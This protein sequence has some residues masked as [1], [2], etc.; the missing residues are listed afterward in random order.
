MTTTKTKHIAVEC[1]FTP[2]V[3]IIR[4]EEQDLKYIPTP[5][6]NLSFNQIVND[7]KTGIRSFCIVGPY[8]VGKSA[9]LW[10]FDK[11]LNS[12]KQYFG[13]FN[14]SKVKKFHDIKIVGSY[15]S[16]KDAFAKQIGIRKKDYSTNDILIHLSRLYNSH[17]KSKTGLLIIVDEFG[18]FLEYAA[19]NNPE[20]ELYFIQEI[21]EFVNDSRQEILFISSLH[22]D[23]NG[24]ARNLT[25]T[26]QNEWDKVKGR[27]K[28]ITFSEPVEQLLFLASERLAEMNIRPKNNDLD[29]L[30]KVIEKAK[31]FPLR[32]YFDKH[33]ATKLLP[34]DILAA[35]TLTLALQKYGQNE[36]SLFSFL[37]SSDFKGLKDY[38]QGYSPF[39]LSDVYDYLIHNYHSFLTTK[40]N[41]HYSQW[42][43]I[44]VAIERVEGVFDKY[45]EDEI[46]LVKT[47]GL[48]TIFSPA[49]AK[50]D[51]NF[52]TGYSIFALGVSQPESIIREL[53][54][55]KIILYKSYSS[56]YNLFE[57]TDLDIE[58]AIDEAG[59]V[60]EKVTNVIHHLDKYYDFPY[61]SAKAATYQKGTPRFFAFYLSEELETILPEG[62]VDGFINL[63][64]SNSVSEKEIREFSKKNKEAVLFGLFK[65][66]EEIK[67]ILFEIQKVEKVK[68][69]NVDD[70]VAMRELGNILQSQVKRLNYAVLK[71]IYSSDSSISWYFNGRKEK[72][73]NQRDFNQ[74]LSRIVNTVYVDTPI[75]KNE[76]VNKTRVSG[77]ISTARKSLFKNLTSSW[78]EED[79][80]FVSSK[81]PPEKTIYLSLVK[82]TG[83][84]RKGGNAYFLGSPNE[85]SFKPLWDICLQFLDSTRDGKRNLQEMVDLL[86]IKPFKLKKGFI[87]YWLPLFLLCKKDDFALF[88]NDTYVPYLTD[89]TLDLIS[90]NPKDFDVKAFDIKGVKLDIFNR[91]R[92]LLNQSHSQ[93]LTGN[94][95]I[96]TIRPFLVF[97]KELPQYSKNTNSLHKRTI[98]LRNAIAVSKDPEEAFFDH[99]PKALGFTINDLQK[100]PKAL[101]QFVTQFKDCIKELRSS[102]DALLTDFETFIK[103][104]IIGDRLKFPL[105]KQSL[106]KRFSN[107]KIHLLSP[108]QKTFVQRVNSELDESKTWLNS[109][110]QACIGKALDI[111][112]DED[113]ILLFDRFKE[114]THELDNLCEISNTG[115][116]EDR[117]MVF[118]LEVTSF[119]EGLQKNLVRLPKS[120]NKELNKLEG[121]I[122]TALS[123]DK[124]LNIATLVKLLEEMLKNEK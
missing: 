89:D 85:D 110:A 3:N 20:N 90:R 62:D 92:D 4:D 40:F 116:D 94:S 122:K 43:A 86:Y 77:V 98:A 75:F 72:I 61:I 105:Y 68:E 97:Y 67:N 15:A 103:T 23:F 49:S 48:I 108:V 84:H 119:V 30:F 64:F 91:Y 29:K 32:D 78:T 107:V 37:E 12:N 112:T 117:E 113:K 24:Y 33:F 14:S 70:R 35:S 34:F 7:Y 18:K 99:F 50:I 80:G 13:A 109:I 102:Y 45:T 36:R 100:D 83:I 120:K 81:F 54:R 74:L 44:R 76:M 55:H 82:E 41:P 46:K 5:N 52:L 38:Q 8:G 56:K 104:E 101:E 1:V 10:A 42:A 25:N 118:K 16:F 66:T 65:N 63:I 88:S 2:S 60:V 11:S 26:Q 71:N 21:T 28:E 96:E 59:N 57:G 114:I 69:A 115:F 106:Q 121:K 9:F 123:K 19:K 79:L 53:E 87:D 124:Q 47:I 93:K 6:A 51:V 22:Q 31:I 111:F 58:L 95:F 73:N 17:E 39:N 27:I